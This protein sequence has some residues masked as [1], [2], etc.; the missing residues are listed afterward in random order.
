MTKNEAPEQNPETMDEELADEE[1][2]KV[3]GGVVRGGDWD[4]AIRDPIDPIEP[5]APIKY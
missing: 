5:P 4:R 1:L 3:S 2:E